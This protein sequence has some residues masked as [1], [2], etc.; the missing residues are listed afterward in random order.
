[1]ISED[2]TY[3]LQNVDTFDSEA[4][5]QNKLVIYQS[6]GIKYRT[7]D[8]QIGDGDRKYRILV[9]GSD[10]LKVRKIRGW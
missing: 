2:D 9:Y 6:A 8:Y 7:D 1:L 5:R 10:V 4:E 3:K